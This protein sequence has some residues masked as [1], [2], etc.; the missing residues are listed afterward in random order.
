MIPDPRVPLHWAVVNIEVHSIR[1]QMQFTR[2]W[3]VNPLRRGRRKCICRLVEWF[4]TVRLHLNESGDHAGDT[5]L[6][7]QVHYVRE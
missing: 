7:Q 6:V 3:A 1:F 2:H 4:T 5:P